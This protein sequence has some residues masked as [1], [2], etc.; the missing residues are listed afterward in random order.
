MSP[1]ELDS[2]RTKIRLEEVEIKFGENKAKFE[3]KNL[4]NCEKM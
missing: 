1:E 2:E 3:K 4:D